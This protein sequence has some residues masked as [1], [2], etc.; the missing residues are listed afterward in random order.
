MTRMTRFLVA[1]VLRVSAVAVFLGLGTLPLAAQQKDGFRFS[2]DAWLSG[3]S[4]VYAGDD[5]DDLFAMGDRVTDSGSLSGSAYLMARNVSVTGAIAVNLYAAGNNVELRAPVAGDAFLM[6]ADVTV[7]GP[8]NGDVRAGGSYVE[9]AAPVGE[10]TLIGADSIYLNGAITGDAGFAAN[11]IEFGPDAR[12]DGVLHLY[13]SALEALDVPE[14]VA[15]ADR[16]QRH[17]DGEWG[18]IMADGPTTR[19][20]IGARLLN[21]LQSVAVIGV[22]T[23]ILAAIAPDFMAAIRARALE[24]PVRAAWLG[25]LT[26]SAAI[27]SVVILALTGF[28]MILIPVSLV[29][30]MVIGLLGFLIGTYVLG[31]GVARWMGRDWPDSLGDRIIAAFIG[32]LSIVVLGLVPLV[33]WLATLVLLLWGAGG[34]IVRWVSPGFYTEVR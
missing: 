3:R 17:A 31:V 8:V 19:P 13:G 29:V 7:A 18:G 16:I 21:L 12:V 20:S 10:S 14:S 5:L 6:G 28:G 30:T 9:I 1:Q 22:L 32:A 4:I 11:E 23:S 26:L 24:S 2:D 34:L 33:G 25:F 27:G 15:P